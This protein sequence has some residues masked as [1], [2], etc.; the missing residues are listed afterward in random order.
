MASNQIES[1]I[2]FFIIGLQFVDLIFTKIFTLC[3]WHSESLIQTE[4]FEIQHF[5]SY[6]IDF[7]TALRLKKKKIK[8]SFKFANFMHT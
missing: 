4:H 3:S 8:N 6:C 1:A 5:W 2:M 7:K